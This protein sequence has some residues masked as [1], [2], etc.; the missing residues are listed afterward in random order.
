MKLLVLAVSLIASSFSFATSSCEIETAYS[1]LASGLNKEAICNETLVAI[2][3][4]KVQKND[5][6]LKISAIKRRGIL[7]VELSSILYTEANEVKYIGAGR[8]SSFRNVAY[9]NLNDYFV[10]YSDEIVSLNEQYNSDT[11]L[12]VK[13]DIETYLAKKCPGKSQALTVELANLDV[14]LFVSWNTWVLKNNKGKA[15]AEVEV[16]F[17]Q[18]PESY[19]L[20][21]FNLFSETCNF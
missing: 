8:F 9:V 13:G 20:D 16:T 10:N 15:I 17:W 14:D 19:K 18:S 21:S 2:T 3:G 7:Y 1:D 11:L 6:V 12:E 4:S 5:S